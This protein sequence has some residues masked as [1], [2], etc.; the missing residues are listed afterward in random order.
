[1][2]E[3]EQTLLASLTAMSMQQAEIAGLLKNHGW[4]LSELA[5]HQ[6]Q[7]SA[8]LK[9]HGKALSALSQH[10][11]STSMQVEAMHKQM[12]EILAV[13]SKEPSGESLKETMQELLQPLNQNLA[14]LAESFDGL[15]EVASQLS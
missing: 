15:Q 4:A 13:L 8:H 1:M 11:Q 2:T 12:A 14:R 10:Q 5:Q 3:Y 7:T 6:Q 9:N